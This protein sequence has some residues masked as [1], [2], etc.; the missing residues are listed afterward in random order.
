MRHVTCA[1]KFILYND[2]QDRIRSWKIEVN[3]HQDNQYREQRGMIISEEHN[4]LVQRISADGAPED[5]FLV[6]NEATQRFRTF[7][8]DGG[9]TPEIKD[10]ILDETP[11]N[12]NRGQKGAEPHRIP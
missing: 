11:E 9:D 5:R 12:V 4:I 6:Y 3:E 2:E 10:V 8:S 7:V 1:N